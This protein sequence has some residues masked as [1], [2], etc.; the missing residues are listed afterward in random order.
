MGKL[1]VLFIFALCMCGLTWHF[2]PAAANHAFNV[3]SVGIS[4]MMVFFL[5]YLYA[6]H[7]LAG[8]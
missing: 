3:G 6:G 4:W 5:G 2:F 7:K 1:F 8:K